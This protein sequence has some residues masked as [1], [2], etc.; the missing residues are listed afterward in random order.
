MAI[1]NNNNNN[2]A[3]ARTILPNVDDFCLNF[4]SETSLKV[5]A[6]AFESIEEGYLHKMEGKI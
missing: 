5:L 6:E 4:E 2:T 1:N 3:T